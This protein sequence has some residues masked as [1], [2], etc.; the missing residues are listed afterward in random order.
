M[1]NTRALKVPHGCTF[2]LWLAQDLVHNRRLHWHVCHD[3]SFNNK[4][5]SISIEMG[6]RGNQRKLC[7]KTRLGI[8]V[9][10]SKKNMQKQHL[11][12]K[13]CVKRQTNQNILYIGTDRYNF[14]WVLVVV[15][16]HDCIASFSFCQSISF[17]SR[18][19]G[20][21]RNAAINS[22]FGEHVC[23]LWQLDSG[24]LSLRTR[25]YACGSD[26]HYTRCR[27]VDN[28]R[29]IS[30]AQWCFQCGTLGR[31]NKTRKVF[32]ENAFVALHQHLL[33][34]VNRQTYAQN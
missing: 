20:S 2:C 11:T 27:Q 5:I 26:I 19:I 16:V 29:C 28:V 30:S 7:V 6:V 15:A 14:F 22:S 33:D 32:H 3:N 31:S 17:C 24:I 23:E 9:W 34:S 8:F 4:W 1:G 25:R 18:R 21:R 13:A 10:W 12:D